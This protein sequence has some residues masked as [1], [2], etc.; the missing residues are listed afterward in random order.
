ME[1][2]ADRQQA[3]LLQKKNG[4][5]TP[6]PTPF[7]PGDQ[8]SPCPPFLAEMDTFYGPQK[9]ANK[10]K[11]EEEEEEYDKLERKQIWTTQF[12]L[13]LLLLLLRTTFSQKKEDEK[14]KKKW[15]SFYDHHL[16]EKEEGKKRERERE[17]ERLL[18]IRISFPARKKDI[19]TRPIHCRDIWT[20]MDI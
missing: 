3:G 2:L 10:E 6:H 1:C 18:P 17:T 20:N 4:C 12:S 13:F 11:R 9:K 19:A 14:K 15:K 8:G 7:G 5:F 16:L